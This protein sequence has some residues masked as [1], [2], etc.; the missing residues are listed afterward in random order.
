MPRGCGVISAACVRRGL[1]PPKF[2][3]SKVFNEFVHRNQLTVHLDD[4]RFSFGVGD[5]RFHLGFWVHIGFVL[6]FGGKIGVN[7]FNGEEVLKIRYCEKNDGC[8]WMCWDLF[9][10]KK[11][12]S[13]LKIIM[14]D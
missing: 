9:D 10:C 5:F 8:V 13:V 11:N 4:A 14:L 12:C 2:M 6:H 1:R 7:L 3:A